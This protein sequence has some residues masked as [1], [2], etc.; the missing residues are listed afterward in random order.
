[1]K[2]FHTYGQNHIQ[3][4][5]QH[6]Q[7]LRRKHNKETKCDAGTGLTGSNTITGRGGGSECRNGGSKGSKKCKRFEQHSGSREG[8]ANKG[9]RENA[10]ERDTSLE[11]KLFHGL[12]FILRRRGYR[13][14]PSGNPSKP[15]FVHTCGTLLRI[16]PCVSKT[17]QG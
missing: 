6:S 7:Q 10:R 15:Q 14:L 9:S 13:D 2:T 11:E 8:G 5:Q 4:Y 3:Q 1:M 17:K 16:R 12:H